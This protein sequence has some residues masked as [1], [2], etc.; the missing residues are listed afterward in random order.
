MADVQPYPTTCGLNSAGIKAA[1]GCSRSDMASK[2][3]AEISKSLKMRLWYSET[4]CE[5]GRLDRTSPSMVRSVRS[6]ISARRRASAS[7]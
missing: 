3:A 2:V 7:S 4:D 5:V 1:V 6:T